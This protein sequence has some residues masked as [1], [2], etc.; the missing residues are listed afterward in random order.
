MIFHIQLSRV[1]V[2]MCKYSK[3]KKIQTIL[4]EKVDSKLLQYILAICMKGLSLNT[5]TFKMNFF[6]ITKT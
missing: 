5:T 2:M 4:I 6:E 1:G 3:R